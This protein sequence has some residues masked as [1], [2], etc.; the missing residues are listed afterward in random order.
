MSKT[1]KKDVNEVIKFDEQ[2][3]DMTMLSGKIF[4]CII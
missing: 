3:T 2:I 1:N 4:K